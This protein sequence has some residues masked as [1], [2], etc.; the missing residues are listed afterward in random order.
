[1]FTVERDPRV[2]NR[3]AA[4]DRA[5]LHV[6]IMYPLSAFTAFI[7]FMICA[8]VFGQDWRYTLI[9]SGGITC[10]VVLIGLLVTRA[11]RSR[12]LLA[13]YIAVCLI[14]AYIAHIGFAAL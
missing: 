12:V 7:T 1:M 5:L 10:A 8:N 6:A 13:G 14:A 11:Y 3:Q 4:R 9:C 2:V